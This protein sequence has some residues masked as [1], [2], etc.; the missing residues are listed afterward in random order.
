MSDLH[1]CTTN[2]EEAEKEVEV[3]H[4]QERSDE[5]YEE[6]KEDQPLILMNPLP[7]SYILVEFETRM[8]QKGHL[9]ILCGVDN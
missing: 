6:S 3:E 5:P 2:E 1:D 9:E 4:I 7:V 8:E